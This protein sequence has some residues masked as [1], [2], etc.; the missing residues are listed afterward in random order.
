MIETRELY[1][2]WK[3]SQRNRHLTLITVNGLTQQP[4]VH[5][6]NYISR[7]LSGTLHHKTRS[8]NIPPSKTTISSHFWQK[9]LAHLTDIRNI[10]V[11]FFE[12]KDLSWTGQ[13]NCPLPKRKSSDGVSEG[14]EGER[15]VQ[16]RH[17]ENNNYT[18]ST[19]V[20]EP[21]S[22]P[23]VMTPV[24]NE[25]IWD[26]YL[27][28]NLQSPCLFDGKIRR[29]YFPHKRKELVK[30]WLSNLRISHRTIVKKENEMLEI[31]RSDS[32]PNKKPIC[33]I[34]TKQYVKEVTIK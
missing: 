29:V 20:T 17:T 2:G 30:I 18:S 5:G 33:L 26:Q 1:R 11:D 34:T 14:R 4:L 22:G 32:K 16:A 12:N 27:S 10:S 31:R 24:Y 8:D 13:R 9:I 19:S 28:Y 25:R 6:I 7:I 21:T 23:V 3:F 15:D